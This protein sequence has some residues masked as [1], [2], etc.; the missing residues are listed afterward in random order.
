MI[1]VGFVMSGMASSE[2][3]FQVYGIHKATGVVLLFFIFLRLIW[4]LIN[5]LEETSTLS[6]L[7]GVRDDRKLP[8]HPL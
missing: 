2:L 4:K 3:K 1:V 7:P 5:R 8:E 6:V